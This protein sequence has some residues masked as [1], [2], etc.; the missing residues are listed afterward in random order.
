VVPFEPGLLVRGGWV[1]FQDLL[2]VVESNQFLLVHLKNLIFQFLCLLL[3]LDPL[4]N[5]VNSLVDD[6]LLASDVSEHIAGHAWV[7]VAEKGLDL[8]VSERYLGVGREDDGV[9][10]IV[11]KKLFQFLLALKVKVEV[12]QALAGDVVVDQEVF[13]NGYQFSVWGVADDVVHLLGFIEVR[14]PV[15]FHEVALNQF[16]V[17]LEGLIAATTSDSFG[18]K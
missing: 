16:L 15:D 18:F 8:V 4:V 9:G 2:L 10:V 12:L 5:S 7:L 14:S 1:G 13:E 3:F 11:A 6:P 17:L